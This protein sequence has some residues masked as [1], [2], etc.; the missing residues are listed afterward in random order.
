[1]SYTKQ[2]FVSGQILKAEHLNNMED[3][4]ESNANAV[5]SL[6]E[7]K[8]TLPTDNSAPD[9]GTAGQFAVSDGNGGIMW[10]TLYEAKEVSY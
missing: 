3:G 2:E 6:S 10:K 1:M 4:I 9:Y 8:V 5:A 7:E